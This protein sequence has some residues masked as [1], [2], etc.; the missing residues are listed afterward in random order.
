[1]CHHDDDL[2]PPPAQRDRAVP[3]EYEEVAAAGSGMNVRHEEVC[4][5]M[6]VSY[7]CD[8]CTE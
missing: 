4:S 3:L 5:H 8:A 2:R 7:T 1:M 6:S